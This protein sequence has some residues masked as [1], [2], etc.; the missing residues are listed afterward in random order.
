[1][2]VLE[3]I[4]VAISLLGLFFQV[5]DYPGSGIMLLVGLFFLSILYTLGLFFILIDKTKVVISNEDISFEES[6]L[7]IEQV[8]KKR[9]YTPVQVVF[10]VLGGLTFSIAVLGILFKLQKYPGAGAMLISGIFF[11]ALVSIY[12]VFSFVKSKDQY[13]KRLMRRGLI[14]LFFVTS[15][16]LIP[17]RSVI[18]FQYRNNPELKAIHLEVLEN[19]DCLECKLRLNDYLIEQR[20]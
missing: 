4:F 9:I 13:S 7:E 2:R 6:N 17:Q 5:Q 18:E 11:T 3:K 14:L 19:P 15:L 20:R 8:R 12:A 16:Y 1:M 10:S